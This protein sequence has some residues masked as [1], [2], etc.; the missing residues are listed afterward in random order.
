MTS[1]HNGSQMHMSV[2]LS[3][4]VVLGAMF[5]YRAHRQATRGK[6][7][8]QTFYGDL[9]KPV[10]CLLITILLRNLRHSY[11]NP[12]RLDITIFWKESSDWAPPVSQN[13]RL[14]QPRY[15]KGLTCLKSSLESC[16]SPR[17][18]VRP[19]RVFRE[20]ES[21]ICIEPSRLAIGS[22]PRRSLAFLI[23]L[24]FQMWGRL[25]IEKRGEFPSSCPCPK[26]SRGGSR[27]W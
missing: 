8:L 16:H 24:L 9:E 1:K 22:D 13:L 6:V 26:E 18:H 2:P 4:V 14:K 10:F 25:R 17:V 12:A 7:F 23:N 3:S 15:D 5:N 27:Q 21:W 20:N 19:V 11:H